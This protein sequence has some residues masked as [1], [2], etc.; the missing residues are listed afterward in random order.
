MSGAPL[1]GPPS[2][3]AVWRPRVKTNVSNYSYVPLGRRALQLHTV[4][5]HHPLVRMPRCSAS[6]VM[7]DATRRLSAATLNARMH[8]D[9]MTP[10]SF[11][12]A[13]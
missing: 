13:R 8:A 5:A 9:E 4:F 7:R 12:S 11:I 10:R 2:K 6:R 1:A 3:H